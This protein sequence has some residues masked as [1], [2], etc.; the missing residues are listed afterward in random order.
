MKLSKPLFSLLFI[1]ATCSL[2]AQSVWKPLNGPLGSN[3]TAALIM[4]D[5][6][7]Y[8]GTQRQG[9]F[10][11]TDSGESWISLAD[12]LNARSIKSIALD[13]SGNI[14][15]NSGEGLFKFENSEWTRIHSPVHYIGVHPNGDIY[16][17][18]KYD[19]GLKKSTDGGQTWVDCDLGIGTNEIVT[20]FF[21][22]NGDIYAGTD[23]MPVMGESY[24]MSDVYKSADYGESWKTICGIKGMYVSAIAANESGSVL[25]GS[26]FGLFRGSE[27]F[28]EW[29][30]IET[31]A[32]YP[33]SITV[34]D[35]DN[36]IAVFD[37]YYT[38]TSTDNGTNWELMSDDDLYGFKGDF[39]RDSEGNLYAACFISGLKRYYPDG[40]KWK[41]F[42]KPVSR[43]TVLS[44]ETDDQ[45]IIAG[46]DTDG[47]HISS[48]GGNTWE[49]SD[50]R[51][52]PYIGRIY[53]AP[54]GRYYVSAYYTGITNS[55][56]YFSD[57]KGDSWNAIEFF[58]DNSVS[59]FLELNSG[60]ILI[61]SAS[62][63][64][65][66]D[67]SENWS[68]ISD[69]VQG[70]MITC[71]A[72]QSV[73]YIYAGTSKNG[74]V[75]SSDQGM[76]WESMNT[77]AIDSM[78][79]RSIAADSEGNIIAGPLYGGVY[80]SHDRGI[81]WRKVSN[82]YDGDF[83]Q[84]IEFDKSGNTYL[85]DSYNG[86]YR[87]ADKGDSWELFRASSGT[88]EVAITG[89]L[90]DND[91]KF[92]ASLAYKGGLHFAELLA[93]SAFDARMADDCRLYPNP[94]GDYLNIKINPIE[95]GM[96]TLRIYDIRGN[97]MKST[98]K[99]LNPEENT[100]FVNISDLSAGSYYAVIYINGRLIRTEYFIKLK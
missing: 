49:S 88:Q 84:V 35:E 90:Y 83:P 38:Y 3:I 24:F 52:E 58:E 93:N 76:T 75:R 100:T 96:M 8:A 43:L 17:G 70:K 20:M 15:T 66:S 89:T 55:N 68:Q 48:D 59:D 99:R 63:L 45:I 60:R 65:M 67:D 94:S 53:C 27:P 6:V 39:F 2:H 44:I 54:S 92:L 47:V 25:A 73:D 21:A 13:S 40:N 23:G 16:K 12:S 56:C 4:P 85:L 64:F 95:P 30:T 7:I 97:L 87:S 41:E 80:V 31:D 74:L 5:N 51:F 10:R 61:S 29:E 11:S 26:G 72:E 34:S 81:S 71:F 77:A 32:G 91:N 14:Y 42:G 62:G 18:I 37:D 82:G 98:G 1:L 36:F 46:T 28:S 50:T 79:I 69:G 86:I 9:L 57:N 33:V 22:K 78:T 19:T